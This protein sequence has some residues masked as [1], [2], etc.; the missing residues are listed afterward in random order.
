MA[1]VT[2]MGVTVAYKPSCKRLFVGFDN[3]SKL[4]HRIARVLR[5]SFFTAPLLPDGV[6]LC[7]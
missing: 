1:I 5:D 4:L 7:L 6:L 3:S 2:L